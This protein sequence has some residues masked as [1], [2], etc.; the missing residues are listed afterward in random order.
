[1]VYTDPHPSN[2]PVVFGQR[3]GEGTREGA[4]SDRSSDSTK[5]N[6]RSKS[7]IRVRFTTR[8][9]LAFERGSAT[10]VTL[11]ENGIWGGSLWPAVL[12][13]SLSRVNS[14]DEKM[15]G[16][17]IHPLSPS[18][19]HP[20]VDRTVARLDGVRTTFCCQWG[21]KQIFNYS[22]HN[23]GGGSRVWAFDHARLRSGPRRTALLTGVFGRESTTG[24][25]TSLG[26]PREV[27][28]LL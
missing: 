27:G 9:G 15:A 14:E 24:P 22:P 2:S 10:V 12:R 8:F 3:R 17:R 5:P 6:R 20:P 4:F 13:L 1:V 11:T 21:K 28:A 19:P 16:L 18:S 7:S 25:I 23:R 26:S